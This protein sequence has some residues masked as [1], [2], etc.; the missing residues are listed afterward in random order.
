MHLTEVYL[1]NILSPLKTDLKEKYF[2]KL[3]EINWG[4][5]LLRKCM[6]L[7]KLLNSIK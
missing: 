3:F 5:G 4:D 2:A 1:S 7:I 6:A